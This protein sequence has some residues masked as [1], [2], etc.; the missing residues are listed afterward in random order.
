MPPAPRIVRPE[1]PQV[2]HA[3]A[4]IRAGGLVAFPTET[5]Y[6]LGGDATN[7]AAVRAIYA[8]KGR[9]SHNPMI[10]HCADADAA[11]RQ[12]QAS[13]QARRLAARFWPGGLT[14]VLGRRPA[15]RISPLA[16]AG[17]PTVAIRVPRHPVAERLLAAA[18][19]P[20][21]A[22]SANRSGAVSPT[23]ARHVADSL[24]DAVDLILDGGPC[25]IGV[26]STVLDLSEAPPR[27]LRPG[28]VPAEA[29]E[30]EI[31]PILRAAVGATEA[32]PRS[33]GLLARH[34]AP[35]RPMRLEVTAVRPDEALIAFGPHAP[36]GAALTL[37]LSPSGDLEEA[38]HN[39]YA[40]LRRADRPDLRGIAVMPIPDVGLGLAINDR[41]HRAAAPK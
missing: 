11:L 19:R 14:L 8:A 12:V 41:L 28:A 4:L 37:N 24:G 25:P 6:G 40:M 21:A 18:D 30:A 10:I 2:A 5:V 22:P 34:Y 1:A 36:T 39:L 33:P 7:E 3:A 15:S 9:P 32:A 38:A 35:E 27:L 20:L 16:C 17:L 29:I 26:E 23:T 31:G 13:Q